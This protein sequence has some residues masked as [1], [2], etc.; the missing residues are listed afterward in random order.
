MVAG[1]NGS[2]LFGERLA[3]AARPIAEMTGEW[4]FL[5]DSAFTRQAV[6]AA[7]QACGKQLYASSPLISF[8]VYHLIVWRGWDQ[9]AFKDQLGNWVLSEHASVLE[10]LREGLK[11]IGIDRL[12]DPRVARNTAWLGVRD[13]ARA[14]FLKWLSREDI[15]F[16]FEHVL[17]RGS[18]PHG[19]KDFWLKYV[20]RVRRSRPLLCEGDRVRLQNYE[21]RSQH[22]IG[23]YGGIDGSSSAFLLDFG[24]LLVAEFSV[25]GNA[26][27]IYDRSG[28]ASIGANAGFW[29]PDP[30]SVASLKRRPPAIDKMTHHPVVWR[31]KMTNLL[32]RYGIRPGV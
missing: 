21:R 26:C 27:Y 13:Q 28:A 24:E 2:S 30:F 12:G 10:Q 14:E 3:E 1:A 11:R 9:A 23:H 16:F 5:E 6:A 25:K 19:R 15:V 18:D 20:G 32:A 4:G 7:A 17:P 29:S 8:L 31:E 22:K